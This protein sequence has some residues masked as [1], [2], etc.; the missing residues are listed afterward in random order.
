M[1]AVLTQPSQQGLWR[2]WWREVFKSNEISPARICENQRSRCDFCQV[3]T[4]FVDVV[5]QS[6]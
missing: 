2:H 5:L 6:T 3:L 4:A 1:M